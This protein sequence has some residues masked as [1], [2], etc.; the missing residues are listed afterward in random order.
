MWGL[1]TANTST[2]DGGFTSFY[3]RVLRDGANVTALRGHAYELRFTGTSLAYNAFTDGATYAVPFELW[4]AGTRADASD[5]VRLVPWIE[6]VSGGASN[7]FDLGA[8]HPTS[9]GIN[10]P[11]TDAIYWMRPINE[12]PGQ[13][14]YTFAVAE[15]Q[16]LGANY[17]HE[18]VGEEVLARIVVVGFNLGTQFTGPFLARCPSPA[19]SSASRPRP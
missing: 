1:H 3:N 10:D 14:G 5:D 2:T 8:D 15:M 4:D 7:V 19:P 6:P 18:G 16:R 11:Q 9:G 12:A 13:A 17:R